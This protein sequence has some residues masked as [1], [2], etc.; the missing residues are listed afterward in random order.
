M[1]WLCFLRVTT[2]WRSLH[3]HLR[4]VSTLFRCLRLRPQPEGS[5]RR[6]FCVLKLNAGSSAV[7]VSQRCSRIE[8]IWTPHMRLIKCWLSHSF[9]Q[10]VAHN[11]VMIVSGMWT[12]LL[13]CP[14]YFKKGVLTYIFIA[15]ESIN[16]LGIIKKR[17]LVLWNKCVINV[18]AADSPP[19][20]NYCFVSSTEA[21]LIHHPISCAWMHPR[22]LIG[23]PCDAA[24][25]KGVSLCM[26]CV[27][28]CIHCV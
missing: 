2:I 17:V 21:R 13:L 16:L 20:E 7:K 6:C 15:K 23:W 19:V 4:S 14:I 24:S 26:C 12:V 27:L 10:L 11:P 18:D 5:G 1:W 22:Q 8:Y 3:P 25:I 28:V 9:S